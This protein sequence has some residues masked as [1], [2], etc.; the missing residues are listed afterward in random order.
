M[1]KKRNQELAEI[2]VL[3]VALGVGQALVRRKADPADPKP[4]KALL[5]RVEP[6]GLLHT[7][8]QALLARKE[9]DHE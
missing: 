4:Y 3:G 6:V 2:A 1:S 8:I 5:H 7:Q 9:G